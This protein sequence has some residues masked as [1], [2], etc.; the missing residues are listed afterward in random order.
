MIN[1]LVVTDE[2]KN[3]LANALTEADA[4]NHH[5]LGSEHLLLGMVH[6]ANGGSAVLDLL[7][8]SRERVCASIVGFLR[9]G[10]PGVRNAWPSGR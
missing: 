10:L 8:L 7:G 1:A 4:L 3:V 9:E 6:G 5:D 2:T